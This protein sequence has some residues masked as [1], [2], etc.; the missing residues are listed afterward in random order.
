MGS[1][2][3]I[4]NRGLDAQREKRH[5]A[6]AVERATARYKGGRLRGRGVVR[7]SDACINCGDDRA[8][9]CSDC[10]PERFS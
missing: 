3:D 2:R 7:T 4:V 6:D 10:P 1:F 8:L 9:G 5:K